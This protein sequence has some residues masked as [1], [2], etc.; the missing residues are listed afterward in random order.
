VNASALSRHGTIEI[1]AHSGTVDYLKISNWISLLRAV[2]SADSVYTTDVYAFLDS[3]DI[4]ARLRSYVLERIQKFNPGS[5]AE[6]ERAD[7]VEA[8]ESESEVA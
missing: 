5:L 3:L 4:D 8:E 1:R 6:V 2:K 7:T